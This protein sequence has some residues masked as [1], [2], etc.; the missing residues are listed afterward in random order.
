MSRRQWPSRVLTN[1]ARCTAKPMANHFNA[2]P[3]PAQDELS[4]RRLSGPSG[5]IQFVSTVERILYGAGTAEQ[6]LGPELERLNCERVLLLTPRSLESNEVATRARKTL[7]K[8][9]A[10]SFTAAFEHVPLE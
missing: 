10:N 5:A 3:G 7:A 6:Q 4:A 1:L 2:G 9:L 8:R